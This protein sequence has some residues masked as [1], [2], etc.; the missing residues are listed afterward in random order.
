MVKG[1]YQITYSN[2]LN[3]LKSL[4]SHDDYLN[5][6]RPLEIEIDFLKSTVK[7]KSKDK[8]EMAKKQELHL[9]KLKRNS[10]FSGDYF[11]DKSPFYEAIETGI[12]NLPEAQGGAQK[13][14]VALIF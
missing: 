9:L 11:T 14:T 10:Y 5:V 2:G 6:I 3:Q 8:N 1:L 4:I 12:L 13:C 7:K